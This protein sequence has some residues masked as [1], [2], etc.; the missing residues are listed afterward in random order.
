MNNGE[1]RISK[2]GNFYY[3]YYQK[4]NRKPNKARR[5]VI[6]KSGKHYYTYYQ[7]KHPDGMGDFPSSRLN[8]KLCLERDNNACKICGSKQHLDVH[9]KDNGGYHTKG[10]RTN[11]SLSNLI[12]LCHRCHIKLHFGV[13]G[14]DKKIKTLRDNGMT[15]QEIAN[16][17]KVSRQRIHQILQKI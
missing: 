4:K 17:Y 5:K 15:L 7:M 12:T 11:N 6:S 10:S 13:I 14:K 16:H 2:N 1:K 8:K 9:H 3:N